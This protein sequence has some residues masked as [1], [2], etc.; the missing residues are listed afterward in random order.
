MKSNYKIRACHFLEEIWPYISDCL[1]NPYKCQERIKEYNSRKARKVIV[2]YGAV[3]IVFISSDY[4]IKYD[5]C[6]DEIS[7]FGGCWEEA[8]FYKFAKEHGFAHLFAEATLTVFHNYTFLIMPRVYGI[9]RYKEYVQGYLNTD[10]CD[11]VNTYLEDLHEENYGWKN[12]YPI[13]IDYACNNF[14]EC[15]A[16]NEDEGSW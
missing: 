12:G 1:C 2:H 11:F 4:V 8:Q 13:I 7:C 5:Y 3:R 9:K 10:D 14:C 6:S 15:M 16:N